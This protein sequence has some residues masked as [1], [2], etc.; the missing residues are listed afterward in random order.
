MDELMAGDTLD[1][2][3]VGR[4]LVEV[5]ADDDLVG[6]L[7]AGL[8][9]ET[10][11][12]TWLLRPER[13]PRLLLFHRTEGT[14][15][16]THSHSCLVAVAPVRGVETHQRW[17]AVRHDDGRA[18]LHLAEELHLHRHEVVTMVPPRDIHSHGHLPGTGDSPY[19]LILLGDDQFVYEREEYDLEA[20]TW[21]RLPPGDRG[22]VD[23]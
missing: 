4:L 15:S 10:P 12:G 6:P 17:E 2:A 18:D 11:G 3:A 7:V 20:G 13:G 14:M 23:R 22:R 21:R 5:A 1:E 9:V 8:P 19:S 16:Y